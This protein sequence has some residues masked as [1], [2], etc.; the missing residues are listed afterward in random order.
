MCRFHNFSS[1]WAFPGTSWAMLAHFLL[2]N[3]STLMLIAL[4]WRWTFFWLTSTIL[5]QNSSARV[6][7]LKYHF[8]GRCFIYK[9][10]SMKVCFWAVLQNYLSQ[11]TIIAFACLR[12]SYLYSCFPVEMGNWI[13]AWLSNKIV[14]SAHSLVAW[15][16]ITKSAKLRPIEAILITPLIGLQ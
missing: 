4:S 8:V 2:W 3:N 5:K 9:F 12:L 16:F 13:S 6:V 10:T 15:D 1:A 11:H 14:T 7:N